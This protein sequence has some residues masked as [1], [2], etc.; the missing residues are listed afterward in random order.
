[1]IE[2]LSEFKNHPLYSN[3]TFAELI[4]IC[5]EKQGLSPFRSNILSINYLL[6]AVFSS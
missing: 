3:K 5:L 2:Q 6:N 1:M 4:F